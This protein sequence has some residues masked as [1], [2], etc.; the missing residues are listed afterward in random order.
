[1]ERW[2]TAAKLAA[3]ALLAPAIVQGAEERISV[4]GCKV[5][6]PVSIKKNVGA[7]PLKMRIT[8]VALRKKA[9]F[10]VYAIAS[11][12]Q[13]GCKAKS[14][15]ELAADTESGKILHL[16]MERDVAGRDMMDSIKAAIKANYPDEPFEREYKMLEEYLE[17]N[18][19]KKTCHVWLTSIPGVG[20]SMHV[21]GR[22]NLV[23]DNVKFSRAIWDIYLGRENLGDH[24]KQ[25]LVSRL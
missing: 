8:G 16:V 24:I 9:V 25:G 22:P 3:A 6:Y 2:E 18:P 14:A 15:E 4:S 11:Y 7:N 1:M 19:P 13:D 17:V 10:N 20:L 12:V 23:I 21:T 5:T